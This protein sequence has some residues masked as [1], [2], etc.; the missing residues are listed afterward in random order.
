MIKE[1]V[2]ETFLQE[3]TPIYL[4]SKIWDSVLPEKMNELKTDKYFLITD[5]NILNIYGQTLYD[6]LSKNYPVE[7]IVLPAGEVNKNNMTCNYLIEELFERNITKSSVLIAFGG[8]VIGNIV[9]LAAA[10]IFRGIRFFH[11]PITFMSQTDSILSRKQ[12]INSMSGK[13]MIGSYYTPLFN[14]VDTSFLLSEPERL[15]RGALVET[16]KNGLIF[17]RNFFYEMKER[18]NKGLVFNEENLFDLVKI[19]ILSKLPI[20]KN[21][22]SEKALGMILEYGHTTGHA[23]E[24]LL[25]GKYS[26]GECVSIGMIIAARISN[27]LGLLS[28]DEVEEH[29]DILQALGTPTK[30]PDVLNAETIMRRMELDNKKDIHGI[31]FVLLNEIGSCIEGPEQ[32]YMVEV[33]PEIQ[34]EAI[35][36]SF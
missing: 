9:G 13:N 32:S 1:I 34:K 17:N 18:I 36:E 5:F 3:S 25:K 21:D 23:I 26:H 27:K 8:G 29:L 11:I 35:N 22:P 12:A 6:F 15:V 14:F 30:V 20:I 2:L 24:R 31:R 4:G 19:S 28:H 7:L 16:I 33:N 10:L